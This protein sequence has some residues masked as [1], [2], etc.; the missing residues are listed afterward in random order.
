MSLRSGGN[1]HLAFAPCAV[2][3]DGSEIEVERLRTAVAALPPQVDLVILAEGPV[4]AAVAAALTSSGLP[5]ATGVPGT[6]AVKRVVDG[7]VVDTLD[8]TRLYVL[9]LP[10]AVERSVLI[11]A[12]DGCHGETCLVADLVAPGDTLPVLVDA[13]GDVLLHDVT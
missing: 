8:R 7:M 1:P 13:D 10:A 6:D 2:S 3:A 11:T 4:T 12:L 9:R 5:A